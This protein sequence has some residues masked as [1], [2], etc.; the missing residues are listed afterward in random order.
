MKLFGWIRI[1][2]ISD[3]FNTSAVPSP[4]GAL[5]GLALPDKALSPPN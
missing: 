4:Q 3:A 5:V 1:A 2:E